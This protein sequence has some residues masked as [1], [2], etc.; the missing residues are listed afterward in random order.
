MTIGKNLS[1]YVQEERTK[2]GWSFRDL[3]KAMGYRNL[4]KGANRVCQLEREGV[5]S[6][7]FIR[8]VLAALELVPEHV[9]ECIIKDQEEYQKEFENWASQPPLAM[10]IISRHIAGFYTSS[11][12]PKHITSPQEAIVYTSLKA[13]EFQTQLWL[14]V[15]RRNTIEFDENG[16]EVTRFEL[17]PDFQG[18]PRLTTKKRRAFFFEVVD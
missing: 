7:D 14:K 4:N 16:E 9:E 5:Y 17:S 3:A 1:R 8:R 18:I 13:K 10:W 2:R 11:R 15:D 6:A 12:V